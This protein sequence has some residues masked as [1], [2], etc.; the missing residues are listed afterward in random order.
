MTH[1]TPYLN[2]CY[3]QGWTGVQE[4][5]MNKGMVRKCWDN[6][7][8]SG[9]RCH[10]AIRSARALLQGTLCDKQRGKEAGVVGAIF[11]T[12]H[13]SHTWDRSKEMKRDW[14]ARA[15][16]SRVSLRKS[17]A[18]GNPEPRQAGKG[19]NVRHK[20]LALVSAPPELRHWL[21]SRASVWTLQWMLKAQQTEAL[22]WGH[23]PPPPTPCSKPSLRGHLTQHLRGSHTW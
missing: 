8:S 2:H 22:S 7:R 14:K 23:P 9:S 19:G 16:D 4:A 1:H 18:S 15:W 5:Q 17:Q 12:W 20:Y 10:D 13:R 6:L 21:G 3:S 11:W